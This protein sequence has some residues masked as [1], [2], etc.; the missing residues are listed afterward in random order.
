MALEVKA[1]VT[2]QTGPVKKLFQGSGTIS[3][4]AY[5]WAAN[6]D[7][8]KF[9]IHDLASRTGG[10]EQLHVVMNWPTVLGY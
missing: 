10:I 3:A 7:G 1:G 4:A 5:Y 9:L 8:D 2:L 6:P